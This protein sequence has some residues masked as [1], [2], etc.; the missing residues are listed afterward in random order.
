VK[1]DLLA[2]KGVQF[3]GIV[4]DPDDFLCRNAVRRF[5]LAFP[6]ALSMPGKVYV[7]KIEGIKLTDNT[8]RFGKKLIWER[9]SLPDPVSLS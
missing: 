2:L 8:I 5:H 3:N 7:I 6:L 4:L 9:E 1:P